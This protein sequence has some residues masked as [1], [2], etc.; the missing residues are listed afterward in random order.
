MI[1]IIDYGIGNIQAFLNCFKRM[2]ILAKSINKPEDF[3]LV[4]HLILPGVG[5]FDNAMKKINKSGLLSELEK[6]VI[7]KKIPLLGICVGM[8]ML[9]KYSDEGSSKGLGWLPGFSVDFRKH[10]NS[11]NLPLPHMGWNTINISKKS[12]LFTNRL[13]WNAQFYFLHSFYFEA[14]DK[15]NVIATS[16]Y[17]HDFAS[18]VSFENIY[19]IQCHPEKSHHWGAEIL[20]NFS[21]SS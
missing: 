10:N 13:D 15:N 8:Q 2:N 14:E 12:Q 9:G 20:K 17:G 11:K 6:L 19:G 4:T 18:F 3:S 16:Y 1:G 7:K 5:H 21:E